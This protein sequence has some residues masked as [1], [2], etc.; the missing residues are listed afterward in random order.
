MICGRQVGGRPAGRILVSGSRH[1]EER[2]LG[3][4]P[5]SHR[6]KRNLLK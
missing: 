6:S 2:G 4:L 1:L 3:R 5:Q